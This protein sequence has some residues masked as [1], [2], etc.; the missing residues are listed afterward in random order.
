[1]P[2]I[3]LILILIIISIVSTSKADIVNK[4]EIQGNDRIS[5]QTIINFSEVVLGKN[6]NDKDLN[7]Y[8]KNL[9]DTNFFEDVSLDLKN[10]ILIIKVK[11]FPII[12]QIKVNG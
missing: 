12:Q 7:S 1:M 3:L 2:K 5:T 9:Y 4:I 10:N 6:L 8:L 11:E